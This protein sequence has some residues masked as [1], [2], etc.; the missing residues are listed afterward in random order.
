METAAKT[1]DEQ[2]SIARNVTVRAK[3]T[4]KGSFVSANYVLD[5]KP[6]TIEAG[7]ESAK[8]VERVWERISLGQPVDG[9]VWRKYTGTEVEFDFSTAV[10]QLPQS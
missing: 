1:V 8:A 2:N 4:S 5:G 6:H 7:T 9:H 10:L 3:V